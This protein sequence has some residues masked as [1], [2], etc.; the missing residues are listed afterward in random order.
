MGISGGDAGCLARNYVKWGNGRL[1]V[2]AVKHSDSRSAVLAIKSHH[3]FICRKEDD[4]TTR[5]HQVITRILVGGAVALGFYVGGAASASADPNSMG[6]APN[7]FGGL[8]C[9]CRQTAPPG[10]PAA[11]EEIERGLRE[12]RSAWLSELPPSTQPK[13][14]Q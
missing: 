11:R 7:P 3:R 5:H 2:P 12:S 13:Q 10:S 9:S 4:M 8:T 1:N 14:P 6:S